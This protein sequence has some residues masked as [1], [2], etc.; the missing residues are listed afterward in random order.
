MPRQTLTA[1]RLAPPPGCRAGRAANEESRGRGLADGWRIA[2]RATNAALAWLALGSI[3]LYQRTRL[4]RP[5]VC[6][7]QPSCSHYAAEAIQRYGPWRGGWLGVR[8]LLRCHPF[9]R[10][11]E[12]PV[13]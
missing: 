8:R 6:R 3:R 11:G 7:F 5:P 1:G 10:G 13:P 12:D 2:A 9:H 4:F